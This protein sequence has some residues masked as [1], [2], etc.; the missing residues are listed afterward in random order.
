M[1]RTLTT[2]VMP[3]MRKA[4]EFGAGDTVKGTQ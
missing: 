3:C 2:P 4:S 1:Q